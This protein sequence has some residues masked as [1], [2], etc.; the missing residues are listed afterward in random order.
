MNL[1]VNLTDQLRIGSTVESS[2]FHPSS[3]TT[4]LEGLVHISSNGSTVNEDSHGAAVALTPSMDDNPFTWHSSSA[5][6]PAPSTEPAATPRL[7][8]FETN[9]TERGEIPPANPNGEQPPDIAPPPPEWEGERDEDSQDD[10]S[11]DE[12]DYS[13]WTNLKEDTSGPDEEE[14]KAIEEGGHEISALD[15]KL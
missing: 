13:F 9:Q 12:E 7:D 14:L 5:P 11:T 4:H 6:P 15:R 2:A 3:P 8:I 1:A 10:D